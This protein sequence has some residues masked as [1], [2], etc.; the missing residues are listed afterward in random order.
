M[1]YLL[2]IAN[3]INLKICVLYFILFNIILLTNM[4]CAL[5]IFFTF[6]ALHLK[7]IN[8]QI[9]KNKKVFVSLLP[10]AREYFLVLSNDPFTL[11]VSHH[12]LSNFISSIK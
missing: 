9:V 5:I 2:N 10:D 4:L 8:I 7:K 1:Y 12:N 6:L 11:I 3:I